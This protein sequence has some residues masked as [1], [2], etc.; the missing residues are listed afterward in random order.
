MIPLMDVGKLKLKTSGKDSPFSM[1]SITL[2]IHGKRS[3]YW[4]GQRVHLG[5]FP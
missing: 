1:P 2:M 3:K 4:V 5:F